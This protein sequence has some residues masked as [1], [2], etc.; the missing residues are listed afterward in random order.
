MTIYAFANYAIAELAIL[1][2]LAVQ[3]QTLRLLAGATPNESRR[4]RFQI[5]VGRFK[6]TILQRVL[7]LEIVS[8][9]CARLVGP[10]RT[11]DLTN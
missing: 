11:S 4:P 6:A 1:Q 10:G 5:S 3:F 8:L 9:P 7:P 2:T